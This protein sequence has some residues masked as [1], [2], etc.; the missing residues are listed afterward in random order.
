MCTFIRLKN[1]KKTI[2]LNNR[3][4]IQLKVTNQSIHFS[5]SS[6]FNFN[7]IY[8]VGKSKLTNWLGGSKGEKRQVK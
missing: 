8:K 3:T 1:I 7:D 6:N 5:I 4:S 2:P